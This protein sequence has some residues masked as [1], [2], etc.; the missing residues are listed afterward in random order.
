MLSHESLE[1]HVSALQLS[2]L[3]A[4]DSHDQDETA[5]NSPKDGALPEI[6]LPTQRTVGDWLECLAGASIV[7]QINDQMTKW[8]AAFVDEGMAGWPMPSRDGGFYRGW[9][10]LAQRDLSGRF[11][12]IKHFAQKVRDLPA[13]PEDAIVLSLNRL[14]VPEQRWVEYLS[15]HLAQLPGWAGLVRWLGE[16]P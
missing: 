8:T 4:H 16:N 9:Q 6:S 7:D 12:G 5:L 13:S 14:G 1:E 10:E 11:L 2:E 3:F 15:R